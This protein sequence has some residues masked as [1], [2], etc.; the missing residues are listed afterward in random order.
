MPR[1][2]K[3]DWQEI[4]R[5]YDEGN[6][7]RDCQSKFGFGNTAR[8]KAMK[9]GDFTPRTHEEACI[10]RRKNTKEPNPQSYSQTSLLG[11]IGAT[12][13]ELKA[14][15][16]NMIVSKPNVECAY[17]RIIDDEGELLKV[18]IKY[19]GSKN[20]E[21]VMIK[22][23]KTDTNSKRQVPYDKKD[24]DV[25]IIYLSERDELYWIPQEDVGEQ[26]S[27]TLRFEE[28]K[29]QQEKGIRMAEEYLWS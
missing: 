17:D 14:L 22:L 19:S 7:I 27:F 9:R 24:V 1:K 18:Q 29:N 26:L 13:F 6:S 15:R 23:C 25:F 11:E 28:V 8:L 21:S 20:K 10:L 16:K 3:Y 12:K 2:K 4:Q 5:Y